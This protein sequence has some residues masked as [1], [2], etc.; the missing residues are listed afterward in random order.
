[1]HFGNMKFKQKP[2]EEQLEADGTESKNYF[3]DMVY[4]SNP[5][6]Q[7][8]PLFL[9]VNLTSYLKLINSV[10]LG[11]CSSKTVLSTTI[12]M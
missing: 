6:A 8:C 9:A 7:A 4:T 11:C 1:M 12:L 2:R 3:E 5:W 10:S